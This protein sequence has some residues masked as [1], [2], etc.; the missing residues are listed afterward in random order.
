MCINRYLFS[1]KLILTKMQILLFLKLFFLPSLLLIQVIGRKETCKPA[2]SPISS[3][4]HY[5]APDDL[6]VASIAFSSCYVPEWVTGTKFWTDVRYV[7]VKKTVKRNI[8]S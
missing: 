2:T 7:Q 5:Y 4:K 6:N 8:M 1:D 3:Q